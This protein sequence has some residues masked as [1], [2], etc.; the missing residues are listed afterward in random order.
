MPSHRS[1]APDVDEVGPESHNLSFLLTLLTMLD[2]SEPGSVQREDWERGVAGLYAP[3]LS[4]EVSWGTLLKRFD[5]DYN[6]SIDFGEMHG[7]AQLDPRLASLLRVVV[8]T[9]VRLS[10]RINGA[11]SGIQDTK[12]KLMRGTINQWRD[13]LTSTF[14]IAWRD[15]VRKTEE[16][17]ANVIANLRY[18]P[19]CK[20]LH[21]MH[22]MISTKKAQLARAANMMRS[23]EARL[24]QMVMYKWRDSHFAER[25]ER[26]SKLRV[27]F[28]D[29]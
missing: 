24:Q 6:G 19:C 22:E 20:C 23:G 2:F 28:M 8:Q 26:N 11:Y 1:A 13:K 10:E 25:Q 14:F 9:L 4:W 7:L 17:R 27:F 3:G 21:A 18:A 5:M 15:A 29:R 16:R 12:M